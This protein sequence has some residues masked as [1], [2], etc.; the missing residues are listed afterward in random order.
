M[1]KVNST[2]SGSSRIFNPSWD[3]YMLRAKVAALEE[4]VSALE[5]RIKEYED[6]E[7]RSQRTKLVR[8][9]SL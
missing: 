7:R 4:Y 6:M 9:G 1:Y 3:V 8:Q 5:K 2:Q